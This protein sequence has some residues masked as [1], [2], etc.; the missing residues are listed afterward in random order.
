MIK[1]RA[2][3]RL[4]HG[5]WTVAK[6]SLCLRPIQC[7]GEFEPSVGLETP[8]T[9]VGANDKEP[10]RVATGARLLDRRE[11]QSVPAADPVRGRVRAECRAGDSDDPGG[12][13]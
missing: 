11:G 5:F 13:E 8:T 3:L 4:V 10:S 9:Q 7:E 1:N 2:A 12:R 6:G